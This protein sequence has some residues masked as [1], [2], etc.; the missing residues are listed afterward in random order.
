L[1]DDS[2]GTIIEQDARVM[3]HPLVM[4]ALGTKFPFCGG[5]AGA[6]R[7]RHFRLH[8]LRAAILKTLPRSNF[9]LIAPVVDLNQFAFRS[10]R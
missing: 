7:H 2:W 5:S 9:G 1:P 10:R 3:L 6:M 8:R 4:P